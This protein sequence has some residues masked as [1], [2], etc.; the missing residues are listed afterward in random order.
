MFSSQVVTD[1]KSGLI[2]HLVTQIR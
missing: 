1:V 2:C